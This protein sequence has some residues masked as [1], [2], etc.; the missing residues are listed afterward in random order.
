MKN[1]LLLEDDLILG[2]TL[3]EILED[4]DYKVTWVKDGNDG[5]S[6]TFEKDFDLYLFDV[7]VPFINGF[8]LLQSLRENKDITPA[9]FITALIDIDN[10]TKGFKVGADDYIRKP[11]NANELIVR[12][13]SLIKKSFKNYESTIKYNDL[14]YDIKEEKVYKENEEIHLSPSEHQ[15]LVLFLKNI[16]KVINK[17]DILFNLHDNDTLGSDATLRVQISKLKKIGLIITNIRAVGYR[18]EKV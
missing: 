4:E 7:N 15:L 9:I 1:I 8:E 17:D 12:V 13:D 16:G 6:K 2:E 11:F 14:S 3:K 5:L 18:C 10:L